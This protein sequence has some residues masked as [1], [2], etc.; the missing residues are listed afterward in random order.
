MLLTSTGVT[1]ETPQQTSPGTTFAMLQPGKLV[2]F[3]EEQHL[4]EHR[5]CFIHLN[6]VCV[7]A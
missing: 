7:A 5:L 4:P 3:P 6:G 1:Q 2:L